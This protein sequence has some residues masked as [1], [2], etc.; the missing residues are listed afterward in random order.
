MSS[1]PYGFFLASFLSVI[2][3][4]A[5]ESRPNVF[6]PAYCFH[7]E[8]E[9]NMT[10][11]KTV[12]DSRRERIGLSERWVRKYILSPAWR[13]TLEIIFSKGKIMCGRRIRCPLCMEPG[14]GGHSSF[15]WKPSF[16]RESFSPSNCISMN[17]TIYGMGLFGLD[18]VWVF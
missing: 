5:N 15:L 9:S 1:F 18:L 14:E 11:H 2:S 7:C 10:H 6:F 3:F 4:L 17:A 8:G 16:S 12:V 13:Q